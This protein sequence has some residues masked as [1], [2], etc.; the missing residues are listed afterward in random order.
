MVKQ[1]C[2]QEDQSLLCATRI[3]APPGQRVIGSLERSNLGVLVDDG[4]G[5]LEIGRGSFANVGYD[6]S[7][8]RRCQTEHLPFACVADRCAVMHLA[9]IAGDDVSWSGLQ[10]SAP[11][12]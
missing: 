10:R 3:G 4:I 5:E 9:R 8:E 7:Q 12:P 6:R 2:Q 11:T 1:P